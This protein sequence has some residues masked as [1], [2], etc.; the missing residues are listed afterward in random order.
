MVLLKNSDLAFIFCDSLHYMNCASSILTY[1]SS[2]RRDVI[3]CQILWLDII[4]SVYSFLILILQFQLFAFNILNDG[5]VGNLTFWMKQSFLLRIVITC[6]IVIDE[7]SFFWNIL[8]SGSFVHL[9]APLSSD[10]LRMNRIIPL[11]S[12][13]RINL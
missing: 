10:G 13:N 7:N 5:I 8:K 1:V 4:K 3:Q 12:L 9:I 6:W 11:F 2:F